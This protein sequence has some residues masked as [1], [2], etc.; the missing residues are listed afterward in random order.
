[1]KR[2]AFAVAASIL[3]ILSITERASA[4]PRYRYDDEGRIIIAIL[5]DGTTVTYSYD[6]DGRLVAARRG[7]GSVVEVDA[8]GH[9]VTR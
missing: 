8:A 3:L 5:D 6:S 2:A 9:V 4:E 7:D 1:M